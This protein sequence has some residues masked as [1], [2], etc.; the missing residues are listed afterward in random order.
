MIGLEEIGRDDPF[1][2]LGGHSLQAMRIIADVLTEFRVELPLRAL[3]E[4]P[5]I[6]AM[7]AEITAHRAHALGPERLETLLRDLEGRYAAG[8]S[9]R[10]TIA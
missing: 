7:A 9:E 8:A 4:A 5:T 10:R 3:F 2:Q 6:A 1:P